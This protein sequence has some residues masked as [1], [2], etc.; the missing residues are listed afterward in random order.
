MATVWTTLLVL[1]G[2]V[3]HEGALFCEALL[4]NVTH[5]GS[6]AGVCPV[7]FVETGWVLRQ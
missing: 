3:A 4:A 5:K 1:A 6:L 7:V 2:L